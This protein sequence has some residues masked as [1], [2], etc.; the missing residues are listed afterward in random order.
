VSR[1]LALK[2]LSENAKNEKAL[3]IRPICVIA[4]VGKCKEWKLQ[5]MENRT[6]NNF[7]LILKLRVFS[8]IVSRPNYF[9]FCNCGV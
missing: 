5:G 2:E 3:R 1:A 8:Q 4:G 6:Y 7:K 9:G